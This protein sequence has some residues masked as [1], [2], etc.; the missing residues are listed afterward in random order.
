MRDKDNDGFHLT[1]DDYEKVITRFS[2]KKTKS[3]DFLLKVG[4]KYQWAIFR[5][6]KWTIDRKVFP[7]KFMH[8]VLHMIWKQKGP[9]NI[10]GNN[11]FIHMKSYL[12][13]LCEALVVDQMK[14]DIL[15]NSSVYQIGGQ[16]GHSPEELIFCLKSIM[17]EQESKKQGLIFIL[18]DIIKFF[19]KEDMFDVMKTLNDIG[20]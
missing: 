3:Y 1:E 10:L 17:Q 6:C 16:P 13:R 2:L 4:K 11:R 19:D 15:S 18:M 20:K 8:T 7:D 14:D 9:A 12:P 5:F